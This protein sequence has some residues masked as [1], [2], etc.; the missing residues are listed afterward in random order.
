MIIA[1]NDD[2]SGGSVGAI[3]VDARGGEQQA[4]MRGSGASGEV[5]APARELS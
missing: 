2:V 3:F 5:S 4:R 1:S